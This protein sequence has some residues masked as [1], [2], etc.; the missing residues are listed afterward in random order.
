MSPFPG[1][2]AKIGSGSSSALRSL[3]NTRIV[4][5]RLSVAPPTP[6]S[7]RRLLSV[8]EEQVGP[9]TDALGADEGQVNEEYGTH[10]R[11]FL[12]YS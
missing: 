12:G 3:A 2:V 8:L 11:F 4:R 1:E 6:R 10:S 7:R 9:G 5:C